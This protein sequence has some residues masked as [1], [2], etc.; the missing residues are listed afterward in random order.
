M[1]GH[2]PTSGRPLCGLEGERITGA[3]AAEINIEHGQ[4]AY[5]VGPGEAAA[6]IHLPQ[7]R[8]EAVDPDGVAAV[9][10]Q[11]R[12]TVEAAI[13]GA[14]AAGIAVVQ[15]FV[16]SLVEFVPDGPGDLAL[17]I[18]TETTFQPA[19]EASGDLEVLSLSQVRLAQTPDGVA[20]VESQP[21]IGVRLAN[22]P[23]GVAAIAAQPTLEIK[24]AGDF[25]A[26]A[27]LVADVNLETRL[28]SV[29]DGVGALATE[30]LN[31]IH[32]VLTVHGAGHLG[33]E[34]RLEI[35]SPIT[36]D[37]VAEVVADV[38]VGIVQ[39][40]L[41]IDAGGGLRLD[42]AI[43]ARTLPTIGASAKVETTQQLVIES[44][45][46]ATSTLNVASEIYVAVAVQ[47]NITLP[48]IVTPPAIPIPGRSGYTFT[49]GPA[50]GRVFTPGLDA[51]TAF[52]P[53]PGDAR[54]FSAGAVAWH[55]HE[56]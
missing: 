28:E 5:F 27:N 47:Q 9:Q 4:A 39:G 54:G 16:E 52:S 17:E 11:P 15:F 23:D 35:S 46:L 41:E 6:E 2:A 8:L 43:E 14:T 31:E 7:V 32:Q 48:P 37:P 33:P 40:G 49:A 24:G 3:I 13:V 56:E 55:S 21:A 30:S 50:D 36:V 12:T 25:D 44:R 18:L 45:A 22:S 20:G 53:G 38:R 19:L 34:I 1:L 10:A 51:A 29:P 42:L 26:F